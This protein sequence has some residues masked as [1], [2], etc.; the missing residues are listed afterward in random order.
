MSGTGWQQWGWENEWM[1][2]MDSAKLDEQLSSGVRAKGCGSAWP[3]DGAHW[4]TS[5]QREPW[6]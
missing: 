5:L 4:G 3:L 1:W 2:K 6:L